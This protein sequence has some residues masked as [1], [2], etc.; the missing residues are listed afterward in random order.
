MQSSHPALQEWAELGNVAKLGLFPATCPRFP[1]KFWPGQ[2]QAYPEG[3][4]ACAPDSLPG[5]LA[6]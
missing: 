5:A 3:Q 4:E 2:K 1:V 6:V